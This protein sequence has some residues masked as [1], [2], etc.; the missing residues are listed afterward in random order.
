MECWA[1]GAGQDD[2]RQAFRVHGRAGTEGQPE[3][4]GLDSGQ[5]LARTRRMQRA[6]LLG[7]P[8]RSG[9]VGAGCLRAPNGAPASHSRRSVAPLLAPSRP[10]LAQTRLQAA[11]R[12]PAAPKGSMGVIRAVVKADGV[13]GLWKGAMPGLVRSAIL[14]AAQC[15]TYD[16]VRGRGDAYCVRR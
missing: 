16:E 4:G 7:M 2:R 13:A 9:Q 10:L 12:D 3:A 6:G 15:A 1:L 11:G 8:V 5:E 14:T